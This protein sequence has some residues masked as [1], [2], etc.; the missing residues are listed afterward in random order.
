MRVSRGYLV[1]EVPAPLIVHASP[2]L[3]GP[4]SVALAEDAFFLRA[5]IAK[6]LNEKACSLP[7]V[8]EV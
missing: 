3:V 8:F 7:V 2:T 1:R 4:D 5:P 6:C